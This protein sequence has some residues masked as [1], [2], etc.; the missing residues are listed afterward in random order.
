MPVPLRIEIIE[1][2]SLSFKLHKK[3]LGGLPDIKG[4][5]KS[6]RKIYTILLSSLTSKVSLIVNRPKNDLKNSVLFSLGKK[7]FVIYQIYN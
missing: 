7:L 1:F 4:T 2:L 3:I 6:L 5:N